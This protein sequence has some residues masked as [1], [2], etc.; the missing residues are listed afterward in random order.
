MRITKK[1]REM[2]RYTK[3]GTAAT[4][5]NRVHYT[6]AEEEAVDR[7]GID[8]VARAIFIF[9]GTVNG[10]KYVRRMERFFGRKLE[11]KYQR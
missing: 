6:E 1:G 3:F 10:G 7:L 4:D 11:G 2:C 8:N 9:T 5:G